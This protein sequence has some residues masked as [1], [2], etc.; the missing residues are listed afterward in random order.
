METPPAVAA[1]AGE[2]ALRQCPTRVDGAPP[3]IA[4]LITAEIC[5][6]RQR[7]LYH[8]CASCEHCAAR[9]GAAPVRAHAVLQPRPR[10]SLPRPVPSALPVPMPSIAAATPKRKRAQRS[11]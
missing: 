11:A 2:G 6:G 7:A 3:L 8:K 9:H 4:H 1:D 10:V 5:S